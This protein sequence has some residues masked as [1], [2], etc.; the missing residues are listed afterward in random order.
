V[1]EQTRF[2]AWESNTALRLIDVNADPFVH[3]LIRVPAR[4]EGTTCEL[5]LEKSSGTVPYLDIEP[6]Q[7]KYKNKSG[8]RKTGVYN[9]FKGNLKIDLGDVKSR[10]KRMQT[11]LKTAWYLQAEKDDNLEL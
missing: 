9:Y 10:L 5:S 8:E 7:Q 4:S 1:F 11:I 6:Y 3:E 2:L